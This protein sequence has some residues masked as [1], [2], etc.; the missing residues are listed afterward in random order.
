M[1]QSLGEAPSDN[2]SLSSHLN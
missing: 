2:R 1:E